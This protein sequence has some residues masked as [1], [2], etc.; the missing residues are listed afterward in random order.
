MAEQSQPMMGLAPYLTIRGGKAAE[1]IDFYK[2][3]FGAEEVSRMP[4]EGSPKLMHA[5]V[6]INGGLVMMSDDFPEYMGGKETGAPSAVTLHLHV[7]DADRWWK[8]A[9]DAGAEVKMPLD[10][11]FWGDRYGQLKDPF[12]HSWSIGAPIK[13]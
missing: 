10:D 6:R 7:D 3:A 9:V 8:R 4:A 13:K 5:A 2:R 12:G 11:Q 1:A